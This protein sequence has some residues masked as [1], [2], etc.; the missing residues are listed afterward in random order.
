MN[1]SIVEKGDVVALKDGKRVEVLS[2][3]LDHE[4]GPGAIYRFDYIDRAEASPMR[5]VGYP[6][7]ISS[8]LRKNPNPTTDPLKVR[9][10]DNNTHI[11]KVQV[12]PSADPAAIV[13]TAAQTQVHEAATKPAKPVV[14]R[15]KTR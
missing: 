5:R 13:N 9:P 4:K 10:Y 7:E 15:G 3:K 6:S 11:Q 8:I 14:S 1:N 2:V 12:V